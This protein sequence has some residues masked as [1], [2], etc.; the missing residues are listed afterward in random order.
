MS[1]RIIPAAVAVILGAGA[2]CARGPAAAAPAPSAA[3]TFAA[4]DSVSMDTVAAGI[5]HYRIRRPTGPFDIHVVTVPVHGG[6]ELAA[7]RALDSLYGRE[8]VTG[9]VKRRRDHGERVPVA[10]N[11][12]FFDLRTGANENN[13]VV[14]GRIW[15][16][17]PVT[18]SPHDTFRNSHSQFAVG[19]DG[20]PYLD[21]FS[22]A[23]SL[24]TRCGTFALDGINGIPRVDALILFS[25][26]YG[27]A[28]LADS[29]RGPSRQ[30]TLAGPA[31]PG[32]LGAD[33]AEL[34]IVTDSA[35]RSTGIRADRYVL[36]AYGPVEARLD[37]I[38]RCASPVRVRHAFRPDRGRL[39]MVVGGWPRV[40]TDGRNVAASAD[41]D[42]GTFPRFSAQRHPRSAVGFS[43]DSA[44]VYLVTVDGR[45]DASVGMTLVELG[46]FLVSIGVFQ[47][48]NF[49]GGGSTALV[50]DGRVVNRPSDQ[51]GERTVGNAILVRERRR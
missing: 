5:L 8:R 31:A 47:G 51:T 33:D 10:L 32:A 44:V 41:S 50:I 43:R 20:R 34:T 17:V 19:V 27:G 25:A 15:K 24:S 49:D 22:Y 14:D 3:L 37:S 39:T 13:Q 2:S 6:Y 12:D 7:A 30:L 48:M 46:D 28:P 40:V 21:R 29:V 9:M 35:V 45:Q 18:D 11:A 16:A 38:A 1:F 36:A 26:A 4:T 42:E 23:G